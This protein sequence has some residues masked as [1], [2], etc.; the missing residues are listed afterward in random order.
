MSEGVAVGKESLSAAEAREWQTQWRV[1]GSLAEVR[2]GVSDD[3]E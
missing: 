3:Q 2:M 1:R